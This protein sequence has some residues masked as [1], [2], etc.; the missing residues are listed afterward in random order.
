MSELINRLEQ[1][2]LL[3]RMTDERDRRRTLV[4]LTEVGKETLE[5]SEQVLSLRLLGHAFDQMAEEEVHGILS[6][7]SQLLATEREKPG[8]KDD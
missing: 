1:R 8:S 7:L 2:D 6:A 3:S 4:W 5:R